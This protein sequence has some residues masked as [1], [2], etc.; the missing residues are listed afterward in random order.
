MLLHG[1]P[2]FSYTWHNQLSV[3][4]A[5]GFEMKD[6]IKHAGLGQHGVGTII[7]GS[8]VA[9]VVGYATIAWLIRFLRT[10]TTVPFVIYRVVLGALLIGLLAAGVLPR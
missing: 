1:Y 9:L 5:A 4:A 7:I 2:E 8:G 6:A 3:L 10:R